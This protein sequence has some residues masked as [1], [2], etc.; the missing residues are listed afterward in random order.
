MKNLF[1]REES[2]N[3]MKQW[4]W[5]VLVGGIIALTSQLYLN[6]FIDG[7][8]ISAAAVLYPV[9]LMTLTKNQDALKVGA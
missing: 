5:T 9:L 6:F 3:D 8:R 1:K 4:R 2:C 7:F